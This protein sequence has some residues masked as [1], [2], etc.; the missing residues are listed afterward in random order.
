V[1]CTPITAPVEGGPNVIV[2]DGPDRFKNERID[3]FNGMTDEIMA[4]YGIPEV[5]LHALCVRNLDKASKDGVHWQ[6]SA[7]E[8]MAATIIREIEKNLPAT[9]RQDTQK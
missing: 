3:L 9:H 6:A 5:D 4:K 7:S 2:T 1:R 8:L